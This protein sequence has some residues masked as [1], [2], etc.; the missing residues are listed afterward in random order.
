MR[1]STIQN[2]LKSIK[3]SNKYL[4]KNKAPRLHVQSVALVMMSTE[5]FADGREQHDGIHIDLAGPYD[6]GNH[7]EDDYPPQGPALITV[8]RILFS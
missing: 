5:L 7:H 3:H 4:I 6:H 8:P 2:G 1:A